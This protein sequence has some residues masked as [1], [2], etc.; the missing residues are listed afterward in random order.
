MTT[1]KGWDLGPAPDFWME[2]NPPSGEYWSYVFDA[3]EPPMSK[4]RWQV[5]KLLALLGVVEI[6]VIYETIECIRFRVRYA[7]LG[8]NKG[9]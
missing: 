9:L 2:E 4:E 7:D 6:G 8:N 5:L 3:A 1:K